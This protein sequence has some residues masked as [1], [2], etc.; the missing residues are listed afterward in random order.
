MYWIRVRHPSFPEASF[1][2]L[3]A[4]VNVTEDN[5]EDYAAQTV[6]VFHFIAY[7]KLGMQRVYDAFMASGLD[8][9]Y[10]AWAALP[11]TEAGY[12]ADPSF[13]KEA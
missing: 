9:A 7:R 11:H 4:G 10:S 8:G 5:P 1:S 2:G 3:G 13:A 12:Q 6:K